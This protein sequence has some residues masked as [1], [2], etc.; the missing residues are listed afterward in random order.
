MKRPLETQT[1]TVSVSPRAMP[2]FSVDLLAAGVMGKVRLSPDSHLQHSAGLLG[3]G[4]KALGQDPHWTLSRQAG[5]RRVSR[6]HIVEG[7]GCLE[8]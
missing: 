5:G 1:F 3:E 4:P 6:G 2:C 8:I 7:G